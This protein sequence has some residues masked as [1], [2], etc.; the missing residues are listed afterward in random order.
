MNVIIPA[1]LC[2][3]SGTRLWPVSN[4]NLPKQFLQ[5]TGDHSLLQMTALRILSLDT[6]TPDNVL[7]ITHMTHAA[8]VKRHLDEIDPILTGHI[9]S[10]SLA[11]NTAPAIAL[12]TLYAAHHFSENDILFIVPSDSYLEN[13]VALNTAL[14][15]AL[16]S[17]KAGKIALFGMT[18]DRP[19]TGYGYIKKGFELSPDCFEVEAF[20]EKPDEKTATELLKSPDYLW[21]SGMCLA[22]ISTLLHAFKEHALDLL[23]AVLEN[24]TSYENVPNIAF[25]KAV[26]EKSKNISVT[27]CDS[28]WSDVGTWQGL[29]QIL[30]TEVSSPIYKPARLR[31]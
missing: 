13:P 25:D 4:E 7:A 5:L 27:P 10:E 3:G 24:P 11:K 19:E 30:E 2:G 28:A 21:N 18:P 26:L 12:A 6:V 16:D 17:A 9:I 29:W 1:I 15:F 31:L 14:G 22:R 20:I 23:T 8:L